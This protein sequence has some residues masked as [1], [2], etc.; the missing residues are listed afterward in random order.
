[1][2]VARTERDNMSVALNCVLFN[3]ARIYTQMINSVEM[4]E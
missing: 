3:D 2:G 4:M 1:M